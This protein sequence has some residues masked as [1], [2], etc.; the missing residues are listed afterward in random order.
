MK[1]VIAGIL[2]SLTFTACKRAVKDPVKELNQEDKVLFS[3]DSLEFYTL[4]IERDSLREIIDL[5]EADSVDAQVLG[6]VSVLEENISFLRDK[7]G[8]RLK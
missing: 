2:L 8:G 1:F 6:R 4:I 7:W 3:S 5:Q